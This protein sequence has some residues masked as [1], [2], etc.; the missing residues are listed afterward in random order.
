MDGRGKCMLPPHYSIT[1]IVIQQ[2]VCTCGKNNKD[3][4]IYLGE[5]TLF[6]YFQNLK[7]TIICSSNEPVKNY[8]TWKREVNY[9]LI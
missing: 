2:H 5:N 9:G 3:M 4:Y 7:A 8:Y 6:T 1:V